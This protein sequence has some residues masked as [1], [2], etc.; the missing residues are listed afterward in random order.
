MK[1]RLFY[2][3]VAGKYLVLQANYCKNE[4]SFTDGNLTFNLFS[5]AIMHHLTRSKL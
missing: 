5:R 1:F 3:G 2:K 4:V